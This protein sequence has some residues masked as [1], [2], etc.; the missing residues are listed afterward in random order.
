MYFQVGD[1][2]CKPYTLTMAKLGK[3]GIHWKDMGKVPELKRKLKNQPLVNLIQRSLKGSREP[4]L[5]DKVPCVLSFH[6][7]KT[8]F[9]IS[10]IFKANIS[11]L[12]RKS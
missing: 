10:K 12:G 4:E 8:L 5:R 6:F 3:K 2:G 11:S 1:F 7:H 9:F